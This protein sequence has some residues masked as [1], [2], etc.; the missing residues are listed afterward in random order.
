MSQATAELILA[1]IAALPSEDREK[2]WATPNRG[3][4]STQGAS[5]EVA[6]SIFISPFDARDPALSLRR[7]EEHRMEQELGRLGPMAY[8]AEYLCVEELRRRA[9]LGLNKGDSSPEDFTH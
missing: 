1:E 7:I 3:A 6:P 2:L 8:I 4:A 5:D 9:L